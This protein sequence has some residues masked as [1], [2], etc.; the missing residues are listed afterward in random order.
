MHLSDNV[1]K[2]TNCIM[3]S[4]TNTLFAYKNI[5][6]HNSTKLPPII[7]KKG[8]SS[9][10]QGDSFEIFIKDMYCKTSMQYPYLEDKERDYKNYLSWLGD[11]K[12]FPDMIVRGGEGVEIKKLST[13]ANLPLNSSFPKNYIYPD[14]Q[15]LPTEIIDSSWTQKNVVYATCNV[16]KKNNSQ[17]KCSTVWL[18]YGNTFVAD[19][20]VYLNM[21]DGIRAGAKSANQQ[22]SFV[23]SKELARIQNVDLKKYTT[24]R[25]RGMWELLN[26]QKVFSQYLNKTNLVVPAGTTRVNMIVLDSDFQNMVQP[27]FSNLINQNRL[28]ITQIDIPDPNKNGTLKAQLFEG[29]TD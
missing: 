19:K 16:P 14:T 2:R 6:D 21:I 1:L 9:N 17:A 10:N 8:N 28:V 7:S 22:A 20:K 5:L 15:N 27:D 29:Y 3:T 4:N 23:K 12:H 11:S 25:V 24:L 26:P 18:A 13:F